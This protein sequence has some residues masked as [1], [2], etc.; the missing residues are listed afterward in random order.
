MVVRRERLQRDY[1]NG[2]ST[3][4]RSVDLRTSM[5]R[6][7]SNRRSVALYA[8]LLC[9][10]ILLGLATRALPTAFPELVAAYGGDVLWAAMVVWILALLRPAAAPRTLGLLALI[11]ATSIEVSQLY[12]TSWINAVR[13]TRLGALTLGQ[14]FLWSDVVCYALGVT[15]AVVVDASI[16]RPSRSSPAS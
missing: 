1:S 12:Q 16:V 2:H 4:F 3:T 5:R 8:I 7:K 11:V 10:T 9:G 14:G 13:A 15:L 6:M